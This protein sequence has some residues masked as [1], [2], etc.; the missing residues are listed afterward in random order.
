M[1]HYEYIEILSENLV[2]LK[3]FDDGYMLQAQNGETSQVFKNFKKLKDHFLLSDENVCHIYDNNGNLITRAN[4]VFSSDENSIGFW[5]EDNGIAKY[6]EDGKVKFISGK[7]NLIKDLSNFEN[8]FSIIKEGKK[9]KV[10]NS[11]ILNCEFEKIL[12]NC[13]NFSIFSNDNILLV[14]DKINSKFN[15]VDFS[16][17]KGRV[18]NNLICVEKDGNFYLC[19]LNGKKVANG[20]FEN[21]KTKENI[22]LIKSKK[23]SYILSKDD[24]P[25]HGLENYKLIKDFEIEK[26]SNSK[27]LLNLILNDNTTKLFLMEN[28]RLEKLDNENVSLV[29]LNIVASLSPYVFQLKNAVTNQ[30]TIKLFDFNLVNENA[31][32]VL[33]GGKFFISENTTGFPFPVYFFDEDNLM[34]NYMD[35]DGHLL[36]E[37]SFKNVIL[38]NFEEGYALNKIDKNTFACVSEVG[39]LEFLKDCQ[40]TD[41]LDDIYYKRNCLKANNSKS[42][43]NYF[44][45][46]SS[47][48]SFKL[49]TSYKQ[50]FVSE[51]ELLFLLKKDVKNFLLFPT[52]VFIDSYFVKKCLN[53]IKQTLIDKVRVEDDEDM[54]NSILV[55]KE[56][57]KSKLVNEFK[58]IKLKDEKLKT[59]SLIKDEIAKLNLWNLFKKL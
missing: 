13:N 12:F 52:N 3:D 8:G 37:K 1:R 58:N 4:Q 53:I 16:T 35:K 50:D 54:L 6:L 44:N 27:S 40:L 2:L 46:L 45:I 57:V 15:N 39:E 19:D 59:K 49:T 56:Q 38:N 25:L 14:L 20:F 43:S 26:I 22:S 23:F 29:G 34:G 28:N 17:F 51:N 32:N 18:G 5:V 21:I 9:F 24:K 7:I 55:F 10:F 11:N 42:K 30:K 48:N 36:L 31:K 47:S 33:H 41:A